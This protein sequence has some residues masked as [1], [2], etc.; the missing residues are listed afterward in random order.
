MVIPHEQELELYHYKESLCSQKARVGMEEKQ[1]PYKSN[2][3]MICDIAAECENLDDEYLRVNPKGI[4]PTLV[5]NGKPVYDAHRIVKYVDEQ[6][7][8]SGQKLWPD[9]KDLAAEADYWFSEGMLDETAPYGST[10]GMAIPALSHAILRRTLER[11][12]LDLVVEKFKRH[13]IER[14]GKNFT[15]LRKGQSSVTAEGLAMLLEKLCQGL[16]RLDRQL[17]KS[18]GPWLLGDFTLPDITMMACSHRLEDVRLDDML[19]ESLVPRLAGY[20]ERLQGR[21]SYRKAITDMHD[22]E[23]FRTAIVEVFGNGKSPQLDDARK[24][25]K[26]L[27]G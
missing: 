6:Y 10:F 8:G 22:E 20:W 15:A 21:P 16:I 5:H 19:Q 26:R 13:P 4:V 11:Q 1:L 24:T 25:L 17:E 12:P 27:S 2:H 9:D 23:N 3:I 18:G 7:P 14:R